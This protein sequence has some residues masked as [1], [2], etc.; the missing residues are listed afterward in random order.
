MWGECGRGDVVSDMWLCWDWG[1]FLVG[2]S[3]SCEDSSSQSSVCV[4]VEG[5][6]G[7]D[8]FVVF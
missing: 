4:W 1:Y 3:S 2:V 7:V 6:V 8:Y 5:R